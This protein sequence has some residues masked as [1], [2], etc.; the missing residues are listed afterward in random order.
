[1]FTLPFNAYLTQNVTVQLG[2]ETKV[3]RLDLYFAKR[4]V[5]INFSFI[6]WKT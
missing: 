5:V 6:Y 4:G 3:T 2:K 1:M